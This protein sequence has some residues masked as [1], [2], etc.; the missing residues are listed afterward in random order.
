MPS[1]KKI[2]CHLDIWCGNPLEIPTWS[3][4]LQ[5]SSVGRN[6]DPN[7]TVKARFAQRGIARPRLRLK[8]IN[9]VSVYT[10][11]V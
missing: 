4:V 6:D 2:P 1:S 3:D 8:N 7:A 10:V 5:V 9:T 11:M